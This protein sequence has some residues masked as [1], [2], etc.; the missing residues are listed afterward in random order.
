MSWTS[1]RGR[2]S[3]TSAVVAVAAAIVAI[4]PA[5]AQAVTK[6]IS[7]SPLSI[8]VNHDGNL[9]ANLDGNAANVFFPPTTDVGDAALIIGFPS[10]AGALVAGTTAGPSSMAA[11]P[12]FDSAGETRVP[13]ESFSQGEVT[14]DGSP[15]APFTQ[16]TVY[17]VRSQAPSTDVATITQIVSYVNG[18]RSFETIWT[19]TNNTASALRYRA[20]AA[21]DLYLDG[22]DFGGGYFTEGPPRIVGGVNAASGRAGGIQENGSSPWTR[23]QEA[24]Y[25]DIWDIVTSPTGPGFNDTVLSNEVDNGIGVQWD[26]HY[27]TGLPAGQSE[28]HRITWQFALTG[29]T[30]SPLGAALNQGATH[31]V[32]FTATDQDGAALPSKV[33]RYTISGPNA[34]GGDVATN[35]AGQAAVTWV[36]ANAGTDTISGYLDLNGNGAREAD[37]PTAGATVLFKAPSAPLPVPPTAPGN[38]FTFDGKPIFGNGSTTLIIVVPGPGQISVTPAGAS[39]SVAA[40]KKGAKGKKKA[41]KKPALIKKTT[42]NATKAGPVRVKIKPTKAGKKILKRKGKL[43]TKINVTFTPTGGQANTVTRKVTIKKKVAKPKGKGGKG[44]RKG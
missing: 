41:K 4:A 15:G 7:G 22:N 5:A 11:G 32:T 20:S 17:K 43:T 30:A 33:L 23:H 2:A 36:G 34:R 3:R 25:D 16:T 6:T 42:V 44:K 8:Y 26:E 27:T 13:Y 21:A 19:V 39:A 18:R 24:Y 10:T 14:G 37:E 38:A 40:K 9:Q 12:S 35:A 1:A 28:T 31:T 29:L